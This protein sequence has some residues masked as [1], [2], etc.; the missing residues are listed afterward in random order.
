MRI[1][2]TGHPFP[3]QAK[4]A[5]SQDHRFGQ[6][7]QGVA[8]L[9]ALSM[10]CPV[11]EMSRPA[12]AVVWQALRSGTAATSESVVRLMMSVCTCWVLFWVSG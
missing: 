6:G 1:V 8:L 7:Y 9:A 3:G 5:G 2:P 10:A 4:P 12:P 11:A